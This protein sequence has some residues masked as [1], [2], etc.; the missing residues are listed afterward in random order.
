[1]VA[2]PTGIYEITARGGTILKQGVALENGQVTDAGSFW[3]IC[4]HQKI[5][6]ANS[7]SSLIRTWIAGCFFLMGKEV[8]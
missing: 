4:P 2:L 5:I 1:M 3:K 8:E 7:K 6:V